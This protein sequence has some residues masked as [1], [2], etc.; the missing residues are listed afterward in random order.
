MPKPQGVHMKRDTNSVY[1]LLF[2]LSGFP[3]LLYQIVWQRAL[4]TLYGVN[5]ESV[6]MIVTVFML[7][8]GL[9]S[10]AGGWLSSHSG[11]RLLLAFGLIEF[12][13]GSFGAAS[14]WIFHRIGALTAGASTLATGLIAFAL[15]LV[16]TMLMGSTLPLL[17]EH[18][19]RRTGNVGE[20][21]GLLYSVNTLGS[22]VACLAAAFVLMRLFGESGSVHIA[23]C[24]NLF[25]GIAA[26]I[27]QIKFPAPSRQKIDMPS[28]TPQ[29]TIPFW[30]CMALAGI[31]GFIA[32]AYEIVWFRLYAF[33]SG[34]T[35]PCFAMLLAFYLLGIAYGSFAVRDACRQKLGNDVQRTL[36]ATAIVVILGTVAAFLLGP[37]LARW[38]GHLDYHL[39]YIL[40]F[41]A[42]ALL[43]SA[44]P[45]LAHAAIDP[46]QGSGKQIGYL[47]MSNIVGS[48]LGSFLVGFVILDVWSTRATSLLLLALGFAA[49]CILAFL[50][51]PKLPKGIFAVGSIA[52]L[53]LACSAGPLFSGLF[54]RLLFKFAYN[55]E[56]KFS[57]QI[58]NRN[59]VIGVYPNSTF[60][61]YPARIVYGGG[62]YDGQ[63]NTD[64]LHDSNGLVRAY[65]IC[66]LHP[67]PANVLVIGL[68]TGAWAQVVAND[69]G[70]RDVTIV[71]INPGYFP[72]IQKYPEVQSLLANPKV[73]IVIDDGRRWLV[74]HPDRRFDFI[75][76]NTS[77]NWRANMSNLLSAEFLRLMRAHMNPGAI[78]YYNTTSSGEAL[79]TGSTVFPYALRFQNFL[80]VS[81]APFT[82]DKNR[83]RTALTNYKIDGRSIFD[84][85]NPVHRSRLEEVLRMA[86]RVD[87]PN[88]Q[89]ESRSSLQL[90]FKNARLITDNNMGTEWLQ[91]TEH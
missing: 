45:L 87:L 66:G 32:L 30:I 60:F 75:L 68:A 48:T 91:P 56:I 29:Q 49:A 17:V 47:Y 55:S 3:A 24:F 34:G 54:E 31:T 38:V 67:K 40:V 23:V 76:M 16:P 83:W 36:G 27:L 13:V 58:E 41:V 78:A 25:V 19:V 70:V 21:V 39:S 6:T 53:A 72:L 15:L 10:L 64:I 1:Y 2:F 33:V 7:G 35:A 81:D 90:R 74:A 4:F 28:A 84:L 89:L 20:S 57:D 12:S 52:C 46:A 5:I 77:F 61:G 11:I 22:S 43:G 71:E 80:A 85:S 51:G 69:P 62:A 82:L 50:S 73:H 88:A 8:L 18:F 65:A 42:A 14:L 79:L 63:I 26:L 9:G 59:G 86:D 37:A 44:F